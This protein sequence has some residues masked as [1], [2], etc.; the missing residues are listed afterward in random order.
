MR[1]YHITIS[2]PDKFFN[3]LRVGLQCKK[4]YDCSEVA[5]PSTIEFLR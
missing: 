3:I 4:Q 5:I 2:L 1:S